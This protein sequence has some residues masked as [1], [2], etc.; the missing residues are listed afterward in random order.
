MKQ[1][2]KSVIMYKTNAFINLNL[3]PLKKAHCTENTFQ[4][5]Q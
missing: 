1:S 4:S 2:S 5:L 3:K